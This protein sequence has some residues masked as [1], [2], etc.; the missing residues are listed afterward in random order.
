MPPIETER[1]TLRDFVPSDWEALNAIVSDA[2]VTRYM[3]FAS[4]LLLPMLLQ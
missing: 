1:L 4:S 3:Q 2:A